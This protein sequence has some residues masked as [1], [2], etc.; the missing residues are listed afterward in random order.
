[1]RKVNPLIVLCGLCLALA[2]QDALVVE[3]K[4]ERKTVLAHQSVELLLSISNKGEK[5]VA[6]LSR[7]Q[8]VSSK[9]VLVAGPDDG[10]ERK[11]AWAELAS[12]VPEGSIPAL[13]PGESFSL[14]LTLRL[15]ATLGPTTG[16]CILQWVGKGG[17]LDKVRSNELT[18]HVFPGNLPTVTLTTSEGI[19]TLEM[20]PAKAP[21]HVANFLT[22]AQAGFY[23]G[24]GFHRTIPGFMIQGGCPKGDG[25]GN[26]GY[27]IPDEDTGGLF[28]RGVLGMGR[29]SEKNSA[30]CQFFMCVADAAHLNGKYAAF[31]RVLDG[32]EVVDRIVARPA[33]GDRA[34]KPVTIK[35]VSV[36]LPK[37]YKLPAVVKA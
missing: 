30:G 9:C 4:C 28:Q 27:K 19:I 21:N 13:L 33:Q 12:K 20:W 17:V 37:D 5:P 14:P 8:L 29:T 3:L 10:P 18:L 7:S 16:A 24:S 35:K 31:G 36:D 15:P 6:A 23:D 26:A 34:I 25:S 22:L 1:M 2:A 32:L 11:G